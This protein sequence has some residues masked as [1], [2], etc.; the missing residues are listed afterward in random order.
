MDAKRP[1][2]KGRSFGIFVVGQTSST[3]K[4]GRHKEDNRIKQNMSTTDVTNYQKA[5]SP[6][7]LD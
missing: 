7:Q 2:T 4:S 1:Y 5:R 3:L 6:A